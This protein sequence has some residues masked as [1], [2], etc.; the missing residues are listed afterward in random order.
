MSLLG[1]LASGGLGALGS[2]VGGYMNAT[3]SKKVAK[4]NL[5]AQREFAQN[6]IRW[7]V[8]DAKAAGLHPLAALGAQTTSFSPSYVGDT[9]MGDAMSSM[10]Q[11]LGRAVEATM[12]ARERKQKEDESRMLE[13]AKWDMDM[14]YRQ[15][16]IDNINAQTASIQSQP[17]NPPMPAVNGLTPDGSKNNP[18]PDYMYLVGKDGRVYTAPSQYASQSF[19][20]QDFLGVNPRGLNS[21]YWHSLHDPF[22]SFGSSVVDYFNKAGY[23]LGRLQ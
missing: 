4:M 2:L 16:Q 23:Y 21:Y 12:T 18:Y 13:Y 5:D 14:R 15:A 17:K 10:G 20:N 7:K 1:G 6:G 3:N 11:N 9:S 19:E 22:V 8:A